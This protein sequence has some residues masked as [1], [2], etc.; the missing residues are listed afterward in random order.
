MPGGWSKTVTPDL[1]IH[2]FDLFCQVGYP[3]IFCFNAALRPAVAMVSLVGKTA[4]LKP[5]WKEMV[6]FNLSE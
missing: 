1:E 5:G 3:G 2:E 4:Q 6:F